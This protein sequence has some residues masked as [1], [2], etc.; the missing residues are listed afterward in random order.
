MAPTLK[1]YYFDMP[2]RAEP[3]KMML[4]YAGIPFENF[5]FPR[6]QWPELKQKMPYG[7]V[8]VLEVDGKMLA[9]TAA[10][11]R[12]AAKLAGLTPEDSWTSAKVDEYLELIKETWDIFIPT[13]SIKVKI[14]GC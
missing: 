14:T 12:Y 3:T 13:F 1:L 9:Q 6:D 8:P 5:A 2:G 4:N 7:Q 10:I 11:E